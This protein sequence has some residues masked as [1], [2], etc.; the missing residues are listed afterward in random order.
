M[1]KFD[2]LLVHTCFDPIAWII[3][4]YTKSEWNHS[5]FI[6]NKKEIIDCKSIGIKIRPL[7]RY[8]NKIFYKTKLIRLENLTKEDKAKIYY[9][10]SLLNV[11]IK[12]NYFKFLKTLYLIYK[13]HEGMFPTLTCS[14]FI[15]LC[16]ELGVGF[17]VKLN[18]LTAII[19][20][21]DINNNPN[22]KEVIK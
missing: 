9:I 13:Q 20:P 17:Y 6:L 8:L 15:A 14:S 10:I 18:K 5:C 11:T 16:L 4:K 19:T 2:I 3:R 22:F 1:N 7:K 21:E 12:T